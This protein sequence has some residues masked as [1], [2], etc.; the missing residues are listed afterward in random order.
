MEG[1]AAVGQIDNVENII[2]EFDLSDSQEECLQKVH[3]IFDIYGLGHACLQRKARENSTIN[4]VW[5]NVPPEV[6]HECNGLTV[7]GKHPAARIA[8]NRQF[9]FDMFDFR[10]VFSDEEDIEALYVAFENNKIHHAYGLPV[11]TPDETFVFVVGKLKDA[12]PTSELLA[13]QA[14]CIHAANQMLNLEPLPYDTTKLQKLTAREREMLISAAKGQSNQ[15]VAE[16][17]DYSENSIALMFTQIAKR[18]GANNISHAIVL[19]LIEG[20][21]ELGACLPSNER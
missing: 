15:E 18:L 4:P 7:T 5:R 14:I 8:K 10:S 9:P 13:L 6:A 16:Q 1:P 11:H 19:A 21:I 3:Q 20:E 2:R 17:Y 12:I